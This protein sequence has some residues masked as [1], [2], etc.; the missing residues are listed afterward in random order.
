[1]PAGGCLAKMIV[2]GLSGLVFAHAGRGFRPERR[3]TVRAALPCRE[4]AGGCLPTFLVHAKRLQRVGAQPPVLAKDHIRSLA[5]ASI[6]TTE[7]ASLLRRFRS[8]AE[9]AKVRVHRT[10]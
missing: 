1:M 6:A 3:M 8:V 9:P 2:D 7:I 5:A 10:W 4:G